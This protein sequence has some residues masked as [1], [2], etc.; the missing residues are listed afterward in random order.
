MAG[1]AAP[2]S[3]AALDR[4][5]TRFNR[6]VKRLSGLRTERRVALADLE[7]C[8]ED[9]LARFAEL[10]APAHAIEA[11]RDNFARRW[12]IA[13]GPSPADVWCGEV[14]F[15]QDDPTTEPLVFMYPD[16]PWGR[17]PH[18][19]FRVSTEAGVDHMVAHLLEYFAGADYGE[20]AACRDQVR[21]MLARRR[22]S[23]TV[24]AALIAIG[25]RLHKQ[26]PLRV[27]VPA[28]RERYRPA[29]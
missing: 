7:P 10:G 8:V 4:P 6:L 23:R 14:V 16:S 11:V 29:T 1:S 26:I 21:L 5:D 9:A 19:L 2:E 13:S 28:L 24:A 17:T 20:E 22:P 27:Y 18:R 12:S 15:D 3:F 25:H